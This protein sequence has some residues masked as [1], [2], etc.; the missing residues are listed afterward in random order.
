MRI[1]EA[2]EE[3][4]ENDGDIKV[5]LAGGISNCRDWQREVI[6]ALRTIDKVDNLELE[7]YLNDRTLLPLEVTDFRNTEAQ[8]AKKNIDGMTL[9]QNV[10]F[11]FD[12]NIVNIGKDNVS[13]PIIVKETPVEEVPQGEES[14]PEEEKEEKEPSNF[15]QI[16]IFDDLD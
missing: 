15:E 10:V 16:S 11:A 13:H 5:F 1:I 8:Y 12:T 2:P 14:E 7:L 6:G 4:I 3:Y 9:K